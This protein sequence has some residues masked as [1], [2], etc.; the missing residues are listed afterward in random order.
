MTQPEIIVPIYR[1]FLFFI[2]LFV[3]LVCVMTNNGVATVA[4]LN[5]TI[6]RKDIETIAR[7]CKGRTEE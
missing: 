7:V 1:L 2:I 5:I 3:I 4:F 6:R